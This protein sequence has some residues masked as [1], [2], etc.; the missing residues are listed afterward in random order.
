MASA[1]GQF[2]ADSLGQDVL[3]DGNIVGL[4]TQIKNAV[5]AN[6][7]G[8]LL[9]VRIFTTTDIYT[10]TTGTQSI[11]VDVIGG[12]GATTPSASQRSCGGGGSAGAYARARLT[13]GFAGVTVTIGSGGAGISAAAGNSGGTTTFGSIISASGGGNTI[14]TTTSDIAAEG[15]QA[16]AS[17]GNIIT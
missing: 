9:N 8:R 5:Q 11:I 14:T 4:S 16:N 12:G 10:P 17:G 3:D 1:V 7:S 13:T 15:A 2:V 6:A